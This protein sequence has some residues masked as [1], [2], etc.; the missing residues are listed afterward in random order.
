[1]SNNPE[2]I[3][4]NSE[5]TPEERRDIA[6]AG[7]I[8]S[9]EARRRKRTLKDC[10]NAAMNIA[11]GNPARQRN[12]DVALIQTMYRNAITKGDTR[13]ST[14][15]RGTC[16]PAGNNLQCAATDGRRNATD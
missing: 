1:M 3:I 5:R 11:T 4:P 16:R 14:S 15:R 13:N 6:R 10:G 8:A 2:N 12:F 9:G 7:G